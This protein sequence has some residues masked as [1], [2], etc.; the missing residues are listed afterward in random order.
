MVQSM[1]L[2]PVPR[3]FAVCANIFQLRCYRQGAPLLATEL[4]DLDDGCLL[5]ILCWLAPLPDLFR[6]AAVSKVPCFCSLRTPLDLNLTMPC[7][8]ASLLHRSAVLLS[9]G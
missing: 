4:S 9:A 3:C 5:N 6:V 7:L 8:H 2:R 1:V